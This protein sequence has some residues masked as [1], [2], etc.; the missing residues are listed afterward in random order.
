MKNMKIAHRLQLYVSIILLISSIIAAIWIGNSLKKQLET[1]IEKSAKEVAIVSLNTLNMFMLTGLISDPNNRKLFFKKTNASEGIIDF[2]VVRAQSVIDTY[3]EGLK[4]ERPKNAMDKKVLLSGKPLIEHKIQNDGKDTIRLVYPYKASKNFRGTNCMSCHFVKENDVLGV[5]SITIDVSKESEMISQKITMVWIGAIIL[6]I[7]ILL[8]I[9]FIGNQFITKPLMKFQNGLLQFFDFLNRKTTKM[10]L[11]DICSNDEIGY[12]IKQINQNIQ[13]T[14]NMLDTDEK[15]IEEAKVVIE[16][17]KHGWYSQLIQVSSPNPTLNEFKNKVNEMILATKE[18]F[19]NMNKILEEYA[20]HNYKSELR[21]NGIEKG[22]VFELLINDINELRNAITQMLIDNKSSGLILQNSSN[23]L[24]TNVEQLSTNSNHAAA[25]IEETA[26]AIDVVTSNITNTNDSV[27]QMSKNAS[28]VTKAVESGKQLANNTTKAMDDINEKVTAIN[29]SITI[30]DQIAFQTNILSL[31]AAVEA[32]TAGEAGKG[33]AVVAG[34]V[35]NLANRSAEAAKEIATL[36]EVATLKANEGKMIADDM[37]TGYTEL[38]NSIEK[39]I[40][41][42][43]SIESA[44]KEQQSGIVQ[45]NDAINALDKQT[46][47]NANIANQTNGIA[48]ET[49]TIARASLENTNKKDFIGK[50][51]VKLQTTKIEQTNIEPTIQAKEAQNNKSTTK[52][53]NWKSF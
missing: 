29:E 14:K 25:A 1:N 46:Q 11:I 52:E 16:K 51:D 7:I 3:G 36:V 45:I 8:L 21:L 27:L 26:A 6:F 18:H 2:R 9:N 22:G 43:S 30:I 38:H 20:H 32:A 34:E 39:T 44:S 50:N 24:L 28:T 10:E 5:A 31:N 53:D 15:L 4:S 40:E 47:E 49:N 13:T 17:V 48:K 19:T 41:L 33:F 23:K 35:R 42:I 37:I 12:M